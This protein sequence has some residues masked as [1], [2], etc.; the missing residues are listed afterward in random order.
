MTGGGRMC[1]ELR[2][3]NGRMRRTT[4]VAGSVRKN[5]E[6]VVTSLCDRDMTKC[7]WREIRL[8]ADEHTKAHKYISCE[9]L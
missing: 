8:S 5:D 3:T 2:T 1:D 7:A 4:K 9:G 6:M